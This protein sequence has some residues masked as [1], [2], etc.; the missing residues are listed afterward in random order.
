LFA[1]TA[2]DLDRTVGGDSRDLETAL[3]R[4]LRERGH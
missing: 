4:F 1:G 3:V 2:A